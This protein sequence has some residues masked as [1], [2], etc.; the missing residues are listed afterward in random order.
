MNVNL[1]GPDFERA[2]E[3]ALDRIIERRGPGWLLRS[4]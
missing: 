2:V 3:Q 4:Q 1:T